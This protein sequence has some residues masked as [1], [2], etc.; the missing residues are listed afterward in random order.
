MLDKRVAITIL[1]AVIISTFIG[2]FYTTLPTAELKKHFFTYKIH[3]SQ[4]YPLIISGDSRV[5][6]GISAK[7]FENTLGLKSFN[8]GFS[9]TLYDEEYLDLVEQKLDFDAERKI[10]VLGITPHSLLEYSYANG[11][12]K[13]IKNMKKE[14]VIDYLYLFPLKRFYSSLNAF[15]LWSSFFNEDKSTD[16]YLQD[17]KYKEGWVASDYVN[18][19]PYHALKSYSN[20]FSGK[21]INEKNLKALFAKIKEWRTKGVEVYGFIPP[22]TINIEELERN[23]TAFKDNSFIEEFIRNGGKWLL[24]DDVY[25]TYDGS[26]LFEEEALSMSEKLSK[27]INNSELDSVFDK[28]K[29]YRATYAPNNPKY[30]FFDDIESRIERQFTTSNA[31]SGNKVVVITKD[32]ASLLI[33]KL[34]VKK[35]VENNI[36]TIVASAYIWVEDGAE[37]GIVSNLFSQGV[38]YGSTKLRSKYSIV[39]RK[40]GLLSLEFSLPDD[41]SKT[42][43]IIVEIEGLSNQKAMVDDLRLDFYS[44]KKELK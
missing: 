29:S 5:Y 19:N 18:R 24:I 16:Y 39:P 10:L 8:L 6:R 14:E 21:H 15:E 13:Q 42:D 3:H 36:N 30:T 37:I 9:S 25:H 4:K 44:L 1:L 31:Y 7:V 2:F 40:W 23:Y 12:I 35:L 41:L 32:S 43:K 28:G 26:H 22:S 17:Y 27:K 33:A 20:T 34:D 11:H 38:I